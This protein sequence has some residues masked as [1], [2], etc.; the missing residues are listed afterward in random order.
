MLIIRISH[1]IQRGLPCAAEEHDPHKIVGYRGLTLGLL[2]V[3]GVELLLVSM[4]VKAYPHKVPAL[5]LTFIAREV[6]IRVIAAEIKATLSSI[7]HRYCKNIS[8]WSKTQTRPD[9]ITLTDMKGV[10]GGRALQ[11]LVGSRSISRTHWLAAGT[12]PRR[13]IRCALILS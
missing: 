13:R 9:S 12:H 7:I 3:R 11:T 4:C 5:Q 2:L 10:E 1:D 8:L 6:A